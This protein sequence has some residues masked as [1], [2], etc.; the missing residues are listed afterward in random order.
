MARA[1]ADRHHALLPALARNRQERGI[2]RHGGQRQGDQFGRPQARAIEQ[3]EQGKQADCLGPVRGGFLLGTEQQRLDFAMTEQ[4]RQRPA[5]ARARQGGR[6][7]VPPQAF[8]QQEAVELAQRRTLA[9]KAGRRKIGP[10]MA[11]PGNGG[12]V[13]HDQIADVAFRPFQV[14]AIGGQRV[15]RRAAFGGEHGEELVY[16]RRNALQPRATAS[17]A[18]IRASASSPTCRRAETM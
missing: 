18:I 6:G 5:A 10:G 15:Q 16:G 17:A 1:G 9:G 7:I 2:A 12:A 11:Q 4:A 13:C 3:F 14:A 8:I